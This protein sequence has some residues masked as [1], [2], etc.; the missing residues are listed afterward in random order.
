MKVKK[1]LHSSCRNCFFF[2]Y[3]CCLDDPTHKLT[4]CQS[5]VPE[6]N[7][8]EHMER[9]NPSLELYNTK[10]CKLY[11]TNHLCFF[12]LC[13]QIFLFLNGPSRAMP[14]LSVLNA[15]TAPEQP[16]A[17]T[18]LPQTPYSG[19]VTTGNTTT[20]WTDPVLG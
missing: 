16:T 2:F 15:S 13:W 9:H 4:P 8:W 17:S 5:H 7:T 18:H 19:C 20:L 3:Q 11:I 10:H 6:L 12:S 14:P 1:N